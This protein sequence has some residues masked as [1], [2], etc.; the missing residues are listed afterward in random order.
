MKT[1]FKN[2]QT[3]ASGTY[4]VGESFDS[5]HVMLTFAAFSFNSELKHARYF[6][7]ELEIKLA[8]VFLC[9]IAFKI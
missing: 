6:K 9:H 4:S 2:K 1:L 8:V 3:K 7:T 5:V